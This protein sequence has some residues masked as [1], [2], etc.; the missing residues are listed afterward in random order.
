ME[1]RIMRHEITNGAVLDMT[2][3]KDRENEL[4]TCGVSCPIYFWDI[5]QVNPMQQIAFNGQLCALEISPNGEHLA[6]GTDSGD[7]ASL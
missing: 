2:Q 7:A 3:R 1:R 4:I 5:D 6:G